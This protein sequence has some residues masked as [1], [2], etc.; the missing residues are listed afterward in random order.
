MHAW[1][2]W[3]Q[4][5]CYL[6]LSEPVTVPVVVVVVDM[7]VV[8]VVD[9]VV[10]VEPVFIVGMTA[11]DSFSFSFSLSAL[12]SD[13]YLLKHQSVIK[14]P[15]SIST[16]FTIKLKS[17]LVEAFKWSH[18][19]ASSHFRGQ[20][21]EHSC[22]H[23]LYARRFISEHF[24][25]CKLI[26]SDWFC[27]TTLWTCSLARHLVLH[28]RLLHCW[29]H[30]TIIYYA[31]LARLFR[32]LFESL[33]ITF[34]LRPIVWIFHKEWW[35]KCWHLCDSCFNMTWCFLQSS[36]SLAHNKNKTPGSCFNFSQRVK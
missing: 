22:T 6:R 18:M 14:K 19:S 21:L 4:G 13:Q 30:I 31:T 17:V 35:L 32:S 3:V 29:L 34:S 8:V 9:V 5:V 2:T 20:I 12:S 10:V 15:D 7:A 16:A 27:V 23:I 36:S 26:M 25:G 11:A 28:S 33:E 24:L 1:V